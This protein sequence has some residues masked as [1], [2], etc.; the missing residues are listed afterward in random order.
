MAI[1]DISTRPFQRKDFRRPL[2]WKYVYKNQYLSTYC[3]RI[4]QYCKHIFSYTLL[5]IFIFN[6]LQT[7]WLQTFII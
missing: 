3:I 7:D 1:F 5:V 6:K 4:K 2:Q